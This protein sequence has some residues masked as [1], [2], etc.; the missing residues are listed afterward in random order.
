VLPYRVADDGIMRRHFVD[1]VAW[2]IAG[3]LARFPDLLVVSASS[4][5][6]CRD[7]HLDER[8]AGAVLGARYVLSG[9]VTRRD[10]KLAFASVLRDTRSREVVWSDSIEANI[11]DLFEVELWLLER[12]VAGLA[13]SVRA[14]EIERALLKRPDDLSAYDLMLKALPAL[15][16]LD[17]E[18]FEGARDLLEAAIGL[19]PSFSMPHAWL[20][21]LLSLNIGQGWTRDRAAD[22]SA[23]LD[24]ART[25]VALD[26]GNSLAL[27]SL[28]HLHSYLLRDY[29]IALDL[30]ERA[31]RA[32]PNDALASSL[33]SL[34]LSYCSRTVLARQR[35]EFAIRLSPLDP[36]LFHAYLNLALTFYLDGDID[37]AASWARR[38]LSENPRF[39]S[40]LKL[41]TASL[42]GVG[43]VDEAREVAAD[44]A[45][46]EPGFAS[47]GGLSS[48]IRDPDKAAL[49]LR[50]LRAAGAVLPAA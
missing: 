13:P 16:K 12:I 24:H 44:L 29:D 49:Y 25:A 20:A 26:C 36:M 9:E 7:R 27:A 45:R 19:D 39:T 40:G 48:P 28:G 35:A 41:L 22:T 43:K 37:A 33:S 47:K 46:I 1:G 5:L 8:V 14:N 6:V 23:A 17:H 32:C 2:Q 31:L 11:D 30:F 18:R 50:H 3:A 10:Q 4:A 42:V 38:S 21:R 15:M 34:T